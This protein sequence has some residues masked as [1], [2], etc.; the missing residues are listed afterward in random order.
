MARA[1]SSSRSSSADASARIG[2]SRSRSLSVSES[3]VNATVTRGP[4]RHRDAEH[5]PVRR[6]EHAVAGARL[7]VVAAAH[8]IGPALQLTVDG[9]LLVRHAG[10][11][12]RPLFEQPLLLG[13][14]LRELHVHDRG[15]GPACTCITS[16]ARSGSWVSTTSP[17]RSPSDSRARGRASAGAPATFSTCA[18]R[19]ISPN[20]SSTARR[21]SPS[22]RPSMPRNST[23][24]TGC[25]GISR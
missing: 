19:G 23:R 14:E 4:R 20:R 21:R 10:A 13:V 6:E 22:D 5:G 8:A 7:V 2:T 15:R 12:G 1:E 11:Q 18:A 16:V 9:R 24:S 17:L 25:A 3:P